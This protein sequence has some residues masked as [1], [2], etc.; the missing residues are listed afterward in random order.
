MAVT[1]VR[2]SE[3]VEIV[4][5]EG[6]NL[7]GLLLASLL[8]RR[9]ADPALAR[10]A[11]RLHG[12]VVFDAN[13]MQAV[14][15]FDSGRARI[16]RGPGRRPIARIEGSIKSLLDAALGRRR[17]EHVIRGELRA[18]GRPVALWRVLRLI[19]ARPEGA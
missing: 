3:R 17:L 1:K 2:R 19:S 5:A 13:G 18:R 10:H 6:M 14:L 7:L 9:L 4:D 16:E 11:R 8:E 12:D 15:R